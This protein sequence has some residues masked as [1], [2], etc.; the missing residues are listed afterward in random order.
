MGGTGP[1]RR[2]EGFTDILDELDGGDRGMEELGFLIRE[3]DHLDEAA[4]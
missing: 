2:L 3:G 1:G 4:A